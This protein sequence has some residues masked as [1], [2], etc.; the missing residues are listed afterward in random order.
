MVIYKAY[1]YRI[2]PNGKQMNIINKN[3]GSS[4]FV[5]NYYLDKKIKEYKSNNKNLSLKDIKHDL[6]LLKSEYRWLR[7]N[8]SMS[9][10]NS[11]EDLDTSWCYYRYIDTK[12]RTIWYN[13]K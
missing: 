13:I 3:I 8:D 1:K 4:R 9:L 11:L 10:T 5:F 2:Y 6:V 7:E 12:L